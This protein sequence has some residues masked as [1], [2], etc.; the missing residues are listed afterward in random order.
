MRL[1]A[2]ALGLLA[3]LLLE[4]GPH[5]RERLAGLLWGEF[6]DEH[7]R[8]SLRQALRQLREVLADRLETDR[9]VV[10]LVSPPPSD[11]GDFL[12]AC[13][14]GSP[15][16]V[17]FEVPAFLDGLALTGAPAFTEWM[18]RKRQVLLRHWTRAV[19]EATHS[20]VLRSRWREA[21][22][23][24]DR[25][26]S[27]DPLNEEPIAIAMEA[28]HC[29]GERSTALQRYRDYREL[30]QTELGSRPTEM[31]RDLA[32]RIEQ[33]SVLEI[34]D[35]EAETGLT[36]Q[37][38]EADLVGRESQWLELAGI[39]E[40]VT[41]GSG[42]FVELE[43]DSGSG[44]TRL[45]EE[46]VRWAAGRGAT[47]LRGHGYEPRS[48]ASFGPFAAA[49]ATGLN[50]AG[51]AGTAPEW[52]AEVA[53]IVPELRR[54]FGGLPVPER[55]V[56]ER[57]RLFEGVAQVLLS[58][59]A[60]RP[61]VVLLD[62]L[63]W[64]D[65]ESCA[66]ILFLVDRLAGTPVLLLATALPSAAGQGSPAA[67]LLRRLSARGRVTIIEV[68][69]LSEDEV[70]ELLRKMGNVRTPT[71]ARRFARR[72]HEVTGG[73]PFYVIELVKTLFSQ[74]LL[75]VTPIS[76]EWIVPVDISLADF[77][78]LPMPRSVRDAIL[79]RVSI[80]TEE[81][82]D[83]LATLAVAARPVSL[84]VL[85]HVHGISRMHAGAICSR[86]AE[87][88]LA[89][90]ADG[91][92]R[93]AHAVLGDVVRASLTAAHRSELHRVLSLALEIVT[94]SEQLAD[95]AGEIAWHAARAGDPDRAATFGGQSGLTAGAAVAGGADRGIRI[96]EQDLDLRTE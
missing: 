69:A 34:P 51:L 56:G 95:M 47:V 76:R 79:E 58:L 27:T 15:D 59:A 13:E 32:S 22:E 85:A 75:A 38:F 25:W 65:R 41:R 40:R 94:P 3:F 67:H 44:K 84:D 4:P 72:I 37:R 53:R 77:A 92:F 30:I 43:G 10:T 6:T 46:F 7:A 80:L 11:V 24:A 33:A 86:L 70:W 81:P 87:S 83:V 96:S 93:P 19:R 26:L 35:E 52:L 49:L 18:E 42:A 31:L 2:K 74:K 39:W 68:G 28:L 29:L 61:T 57:S 12:S 71:G 21:L 1:S 62:D 8:M 88:H 9:R 16:A 36:R 64:C 89:A 45:A 20:A 48:G 55:A 78:A 82:R 91:C 50:A 14:R 60:E 63:H 54:R 23:L 66:L 17:E 5:P 90:E 73:N